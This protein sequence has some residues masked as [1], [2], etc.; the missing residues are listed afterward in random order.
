MLKFKIITTVSIVVI[1]VLLVCN[2][3]FDSSWLWILLPITVWLLVTTIG[4]FSMSYG[5]FLTSFTSKDSITSKKIALTFDDG[6]H[7]ELTY[8]ILDVLDRFNAKA[9]FF[10]IGKQIEKHPEV[11]KEI[12]RRGHAIGNHSYSHSNFID[13]S[14]QQ[15]WLEEIRNTDLIIEK[16]T[17]KP[18]NLFRPPFGVTTPKLAKAIKETKHNVIGWNNRSFDTILKNKTLVLK[19]II[20]HISP[21]GII[22]LHDTQPN[23]LYILE[24]LL[25]HLK[26]HEF[27][28][29]TIN[30][31]LNE[32]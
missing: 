28:A 6:P 25:F 15:K 2:V 21:G 30:N 12:A 14:S 20:K 19:R 5:Y 10:C 22:L 23:T 16:I 8:S 1:L 17:G 3:Y 31:L 11:L 4:S 9:T 26:Q 18:S 32:I 24:R 27:E 7:P 29:V 13:F